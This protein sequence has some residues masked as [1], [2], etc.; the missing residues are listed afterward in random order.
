MSAEWVEMEAFEEGLKVAKRLKK[1]H[2]ILETN[3]ANL[4]NKINNRKDGVTIMGSHIKALC[5]QFDKY[6]S[7]KVNWTYK[8]CNLV[9]DFICY[10]VIQND[11]NWCFHIN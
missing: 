7:V 11:C 4:V 10:F 2:I 8:S 9:A 5:I 6:E 1:K 3:C